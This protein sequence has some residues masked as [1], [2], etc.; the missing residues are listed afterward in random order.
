MQHLTNLAAQFERASQAYAA[1]NAISR[2][3]DWFV[4]KMQEELGELVQIWLKLTDRGRTHG[5]QR[6]ALE[7]EL[8][9]ETA[10][11]LGHV[12]LFMNRHDIDI[13]DAINRKWRFNPSASES[14][15]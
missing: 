8:A 14:K 6:E 5:V 12:L 13:T 1:Q 11:L 2:D 7:E 3:E 4:L 9:N 15:D 10:D